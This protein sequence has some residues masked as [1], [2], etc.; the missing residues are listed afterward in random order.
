MS[1]DARCAHEGSVEGQRGRIGRSPKEIRAALLPEDVGEFDREFRRVMDEAKER[2]DLTPVN[3]CLERWWWMAVS[4]QDPE[5]HRRMLEVADRAQRGEPVS[6]V[7]W[8]E[9]KAELGL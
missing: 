8:S 5:A 3:E 4:S 6:S 2:L 1:A 7:P 9:L